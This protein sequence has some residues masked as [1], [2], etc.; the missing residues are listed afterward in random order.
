MPSRDVFNRYVAASLVGLLALSVHTTWAGPQ[1]D[2]PE[3]VMQGAAEAAA[4]FR[5]AASAVS[6]NDAFLDHLRTDRTYAAAILAA[7]QKSDRAGLVTLMKRFSPSGDI[8]ITEL[9]P[10]L[11]IHY[12]KVVKTDHGDITIDTC[13]STD[14]GCAGAGFASIT[15]K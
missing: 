12:R 9:N 14:H 8:S 2:T 6:E 11:T 4:H 5:G 10:D 1:K 3:L 13:I 15:M 7:G